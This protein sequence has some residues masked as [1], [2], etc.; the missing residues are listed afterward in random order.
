[1]RNRDGEKMGLFGR[2]EGVEQGLIVDGL[3]QRV[4]EL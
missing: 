2:G 4:V 1:M 3:V